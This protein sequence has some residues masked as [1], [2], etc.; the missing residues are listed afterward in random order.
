MRAFGVVGRVPHHPLVSLAIIVRV[1]GG[2]AIFA[3]FRRG[4]GNVGIFRFVAFHRRVPGRCALPQCF[5]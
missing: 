3:G 1:G 2:V 4:I 5:P